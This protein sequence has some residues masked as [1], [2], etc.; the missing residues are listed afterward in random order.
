[1]NHYNHETHYTGHKKRPKLH[2]II[3]KKLGKLQWAMLVQCLK[4]TCMKRQNPSQADLSSTTHPNGKVPSVWLLDT[5]HMYE[6]TL[7]WR[8]LL[9][10]RLFLLIQPDVCKLLVKVPLIWY[11]YGYGPLNVSE[12]HCGWRNC[13]L[14]YFILSVHPNRVIS[15]LSKSTEWTFHCLNSNL[16]AWMIAS[17]IMNCWRTF[18]KWI[19]SLA[20]FHM[21]YHFILH[22][23]YE[24]DLGS[25][26]ME[27]ID[28]S[29]C[30]LPCL[31]GRFW[32]PN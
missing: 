1:M 2:S 31:V 5:C 26:L 23:T 28:A 8:K 13:E 12:I 19:S 27:T 21:I 17:H 15:I 3:R 6:Y 10:N 32:S 22:S 9:P 25:S 7:Q 30:H 16:C 29:S 11:Y 20:V 24:T 14:P 4:S 18:L